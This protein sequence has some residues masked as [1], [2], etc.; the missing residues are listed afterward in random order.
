M[1]V[2]LKKR[3]ELT[4]LHRIQPI[5]GN[6]DEDIETRQDSHAKHNPIRQVVEWNDSPRETTKST[7]RSDTLWTTRPKEQVDLPYPLFRPVSIWL[8]ESVLMGYC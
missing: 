3:E 1:K 6:R 7:T 5:P 4:H 8:L 2:N